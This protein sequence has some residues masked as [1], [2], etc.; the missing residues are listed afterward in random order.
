MPVKKTVAGRIE[1]D[2]TKSTNNY[3]MQLIRDEKAEDGI[4]VCTKHQTAGKGQRGKIWITP[5]GTAITMTYIAKADFLAPVQYFQLLATTAVAVRNWAARYIG[6]EETK[7]KWPNDLFWRDRKAGGMLIENILQGEV[8]KWAVIGVGINIRQTDFPPD[9]G[10]AVSF[11]Q[12]TG[13]TFEINTLTEELG[14]AISDAIHLLKTSGFEYILK[15]YNTHLWRKGYTATLQ[16]Q[17]EQIQGEIA[18]ATENGMLVVHT[19]TERHF[20]FQEISW[21]I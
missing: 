17:N 16:H 14:N 21:I 19:D 9:I 10:K 2:E 6:E 5:P 15:E 18:G 20:H 4:V 1:L 13:R 8:W 3:A 7:I 12:I 11:L